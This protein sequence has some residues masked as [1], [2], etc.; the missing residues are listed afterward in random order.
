VVLVADLFPSVACPCRWSILVG[1]P[2]SSAYD[3]V[4]SR[5]CLAVADVGAGLLEGGGGC[6]WGVTW[7]VGLV[8]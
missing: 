4:A 7:G 3:A 1:D 6:G 8:H 5:C 2:S